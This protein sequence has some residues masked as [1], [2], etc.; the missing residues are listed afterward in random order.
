MA[1]R[2]KHGTLL[3][4]PNLVKK[5]YLETYRERLKNI[6]MKTEL[7]DLFCLKSELWDWRLDEL[8]G[9]KT[10]MWTVEDL[11]KVLKGLKTNKTRDP[12]GLINEIFKPGFL[13]ED[14]KLGMLAL[15]N[16]IKKEQKLPKFLQFANITTI[17]KKKGSRH[18][19][20]NDR[21][22]FV[23]S[24]MRMNLDSLIYEEKYPLVDSQMSDSNI[25]ARKNR[26]IR[27]H[28]FIVNGIINSVLNGNDD[29]VDIQIYDV[30]KCFD[31][32]WLEDCMMDIYEKIPP[33]ARDDKLSLIYKMNQ[34]NYVAVRKMD[35][36]G[37]QV[38]G[39]Q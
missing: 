11:E 13:G 38:H 33:E 5:L 39:V 1:K 22:I 10:K 27:D 2:D 32:L 14:L 12:H 15:L 9:R 19:I 24:V 8:E 35:C 16:T 18:E 7:E 26:N 17:Y 6:K 3:T 36:Q 30:E 21:G 4:A 28:L 23:V 20:N 29:S 31:A 34:D 25:C 37:L